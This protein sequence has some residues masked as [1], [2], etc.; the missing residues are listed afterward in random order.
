VRLLVLGANGFIGSHLVRAV[1]ARTAWRIAAID[2]DD[3]KLGGVIGDPRVEFERGD[4]AERRPWVEAQVRA[5]DVVVPL[6]AIAT[7]ATYVRDPLRVFELTFE[8]NLRV[9]RQC[10]DAGTRVV[11]PSSSE[12]YGKC[13]DE[14][15]VEDESSLVLGPIASQRWIYAASKQLLE[16][17][18]WAHGQADRLR[19]TVFRPFNWIGP[20]LDDPP[21]SPGGDARVVAEFLENLVRGEPI[22]LVDGGRQRRCLT[23]IDDGIDCLLRI[24]ENRHGRADGQI[25]N[26]GNPANECSVADLAL[27]LRRLFAAHPRGRADAGWSDIVEVPSREFYGPGYEDVPRRRPSI[28]RARAVLGWEPRVGLDEALRLTLDG[29]LASPGRRAVPLPAAG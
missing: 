24:L 8:E 19:F 16:R 13:P 23:Y 17:V 1:L 18:I 9:I 20:G 15:F 2:L 22:R 12:V 10:A 25:F 3:S 6:V 29:R 21:A 27:A 26:V 11:F 5:A 28:E 14:T 7:P 4:V